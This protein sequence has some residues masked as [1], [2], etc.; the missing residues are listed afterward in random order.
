M[1]ANPP[2]FVVGEPEIIRAPKLNKLEGRVTTVEETGGGGGTTLTIDGGDAGAN[3]GSS[4]SI[5][6]GGA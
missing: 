3:G 2:Y 1:A 5:D 4:M 6:G